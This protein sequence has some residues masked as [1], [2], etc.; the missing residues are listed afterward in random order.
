[1]SD[2]SNFDIDLNEYEAD[3]NALNENKED[4]PKKK[5]YKE[6]PDGTYMVEFGEKDRLTLAPTKAGD[7]LMIKGSLTITEGEHERQKIWINKPVLGGGLKPISLKIGLDFI[8]SF[9]PTPEVA[10]LGK[11]EALKADI[12]SACE[13]LR[14]YMFEIEL[15][16]NDKGF[17]NIKVKE[18]FETEEAP[19]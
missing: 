18:V 15:W 1:M 3:V 5:E 9:K 10:Y 8:N 6:V 11:T 7:K 13:S 16:T 17:K 4:K 19:F 12:E 2:L 14:P